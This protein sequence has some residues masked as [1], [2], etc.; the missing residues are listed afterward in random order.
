MCLKELVG[1][2]FP[3]VSFDQRHTRSFERGHLV[4]ACAL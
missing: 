2:H 3:K 4:R 1:K